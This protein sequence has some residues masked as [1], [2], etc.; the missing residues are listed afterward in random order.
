[1]SIE[2]SRADEPHDV[3]AAEPTKG[4]KVAIADILEALSKYRLALIFGWQ[5]VAQRYRRS[6]VGAFWLTLNMAVFIGALGLIFGTL[7]QSEMH[8]FLPHLCAGVITWGFISTCLSEGCT[9]FTSSEG[10]ILQVRM[11]LFTHIMR[12]LW[13]NIIIF[14]HN[15]V[16]FPILLLVLGRMID[17]NA[18]WAIPGFVLLCLNLSWM[19]LILAILCARFRDMTQVVINILQVLFYATPIMWM[20]KILPNNVSRAFIELNPFY[21]FIELVRAPLFGYPPSTL[22]WTFGFAFAIIGWVVAILFFGRYRWR[23]AYWL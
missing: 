20:V 3:V 9:T 7:F 15:I 14:A 13:R 2:I 12:V 1:M 11:P 19:M 17:F 10:I 6:R 8:D 23:I 5:D 4:A 22:D 21:H 16:I 18:L